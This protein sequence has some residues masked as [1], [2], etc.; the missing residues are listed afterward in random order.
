MASPR[1]PAVTT[2]KSTK[3][4]DIPA[5]VD[6]SRHLDKA[7]LL[8]LPDLPHRI[9]LLIRLLGVGGR[10]TLASTK[11][12][13]AQPGVVRMWQEW[14]LRHAGVWRRNSMMGHW[15]A[16]CRTVLT[17]QMRSSI[18]VLTAP[19]PGMFRNGKHFHIEPTSIHRLRCC[20]HVYQFRQAQHAPSSQQ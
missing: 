11:V 10:R 20:Y 17:L 7:H 15:H 18:I 19:A 13:T 14:R 9:L 8:H 16:V 1:A 3:T 5:H 2:A 12:E 4:V 6:C